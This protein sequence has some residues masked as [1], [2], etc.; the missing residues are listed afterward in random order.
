MNIISD[1][2]LN[3]FMFRRKNEDQDNS[4]KDENLYGPVRIED[5]KVD[6]KYVKNIMYFTYENGSTKVNI[7]DMDG[8]KIKSI[9]L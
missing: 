1:S 6:D 5:Y 3:I 7:S 8:N 4:K 2:K 9:S